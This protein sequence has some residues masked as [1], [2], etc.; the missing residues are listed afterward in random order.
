MVCA[1]DVFSGF[2]ENQPTVCAVFRSISVRTNACRNASPAQKLLL[3]LRR[4]LLRAHDQTS[5]Q[6]NREKEGLPFIAERMALL[7]LVFYEF[8]DSGLL[9]RPI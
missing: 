7:L 8:Y 5:T 6:A 1:I 9:R 3:A 4:L 2:A